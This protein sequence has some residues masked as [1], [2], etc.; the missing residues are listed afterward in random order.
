[1]TWTYG[2]DPAANDRDE[3][4][5]LTGDTDT[6]DQL[7][8]DEEIAHAVTIAGST[9][10][11]AAMCLDTL[12]SK[13][14]RDVD[15]KLSKGSESS[16][17][18]SKAFRAAASALRSGIGTALTSLSFGGLTKSGKQTLRSDSDAVQPAFERGSFDN[19]SAPDNPTAV[20]DDTE[21]TS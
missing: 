6:N 7:I 14:A 10:M 17:Q 16:S 19:P 3:V 13:F 15:N 2:G 8:T 12:A 11:A 1:M 9:Q 5:W 18:R 4:R 21:S 20:S